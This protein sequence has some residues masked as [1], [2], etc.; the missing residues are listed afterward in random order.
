[1]EGQKISTRCFFDEHSVRSWLES[2]FVEAAYSH[3]LNFIN[4]KR[5]IEETFED[6][7]M[8][9]IDVYKNSA[10]KL[11][12]LRDWL[13]TGQILF[14]AGRI[15][16]L[17]EKFNDSA[18]F[19]IKAAESFSN[20]ARLYR[21]AASAYIIGIAILTTLKKSKREIKSHIEKAILRLRWELERYKLSR[22]YEQMA[23][24]YDDISLLYLVTNEYEKAIETLEKAA[25]SYLKHNKKHFQIM[26]GL[27]YSLISAIQREILEKIGWSKYNK[28]AYECFINGGDPVAGSIE[29][30]K[31]NLYISE[32]ENTIKDIIEASN[33]IKDSASLTASISLLMSLYPVALKMNLDDELLNTLFGTLIENLKKGD[34]VKLEEMFRVFYATKYKKPIELDYLGR[35]KRTDGAFVRI[36]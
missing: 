10:E 28:M 24:T 36:W 25:V 5:S 27:R 1:M 21:Q 11:T 34:E 15:S 17:C 18:K 35:Y 4:C 14:D 31:I 6:E 8:M 32:D 16:I 22:D 20:S 29:L 2:G 33:K 19:F 23:Q 30:L 12:E 7:C 13:S 3:V 9:I 26:A